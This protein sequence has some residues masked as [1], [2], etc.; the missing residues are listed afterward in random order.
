MDRGTLNAGAVGMHAIYLPEE[1]EIGWRTTRNARSRG[2]AVIRA[3]WIGTFILRRRVAAAHPGPNA[4]GLGQ[5][6]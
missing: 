2:Y 1:P 4:N 5:N 6:A 3:R